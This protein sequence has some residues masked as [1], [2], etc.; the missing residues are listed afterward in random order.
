M[1]PDQANGEEDYFRRGVVRSVQAGIVWL[2]AVFTGGFSA[3]GA[4]FSEYQVKAAW[5]ANFTQ[6]VK[7]PAKAFPDAA[8]P[9]QIGILGDDPFGGA[10][11]TLVQGQSVA[12]RKIVIRRAR[13]A[14]DVKNCQIVFIS[15]SENASIAELIGA[16]QGAILTV[17]ESEQ[18]I[19]HGGVIGIR[20]EG[21]RLRLAI[22]A[23]A[24]RRAGLHLS[25]LLQDLDR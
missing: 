14:E 9:F 24:A 22:N 2:L 15:K 3:H 5:V 17:G 16:L 11:D 6:F 4:D 23:E 10:L 18:F 12:G 8:A 13:K 19:R 7:W 1:N 21:T 20:L 25:S